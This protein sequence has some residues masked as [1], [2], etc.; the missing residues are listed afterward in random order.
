MSCKKIDNEWKGYYNAYKECLAFT[1]LS[2]E[3]YKQG[4]I[5]GIA[6]SEIRNECKLTKPPTNYCLVVDKEI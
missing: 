3:Q 4:I 2:E 5:N 6:P 1:P